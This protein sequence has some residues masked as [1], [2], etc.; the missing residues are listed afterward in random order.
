VPTLP[1]AP[2]LATALAGVA[3]VAGAAPAAGARAA[4][5]GEPCAPGTGVT[6]VVDF[7][8]LGGGTRVACAAEV[9]GSGT[10]AVTA[11]GFDLAGVVSQ[12]GFVCRV[13]GR[14]GP[15]AEDC[16][17]TPPE[18]AYWGLFVA[19]AAGAPWTYATVGIDSLE[20][21]PG[22]YVGFRFQD[23]S[24]RVPPG[25]EPLAGVP[26]AAPAAA[27][28]DTK[29]APGGESGDGSGG[30]SG[31]GSGD[32]SGTGPGGGPGGTALVPVAAAAVAGLLAATYLVA[33][34]RRSA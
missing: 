24:G 8:P 11:A 17:R 30:G 25:R 21:A 15:E 14:P 26:A 1:S 12:P 10:A 28:T 19:D 16:R 3:L 5:Q 34:R 33:R 29:G 2:A 13:E 9:S 27:D 20:P 31:G 6:V 18:S 7:G 32:G 23:G 4:G 22:S